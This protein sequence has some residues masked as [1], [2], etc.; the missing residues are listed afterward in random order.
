MAD[1][2]GEKVL[3]PSTGQEFV[4]RATD[5]MITPQPYS[6]PTDFAAQ[7][8]TP[9]DTTE[10]I[11]MCEEISVWN[12]IPEQTTGL[13]QE[14]WREMDELEF[15]S[16]SSYIA[17]ADG[18]CPEEYDHDGN[19]TT[20]SLKNLGAKKTLSVSDIKHSAAV[21]AA[22]WNGINNIL[23]GMGGSSGMPGGADQATFI[24]ET[25]GDVKDK[26]VRLAMT[27]VMNGWDRLLVEGD[28]NNNSLEFDGIENWATN[29]SCSMHTNDNSSSGTFSSTSY[30]RFLSESCA[31][32]TRIFGHPQAVQEMMSSYF[33]LGYQG[34]QIINHASGDRIIP[35]FNFA[36][37]VNTGVGRLEVVADTN[38]N[39]T[40]MGNGAFQAHLYALRMSHNGEPLVYKST[41][42]P[43]SMKDLA[44]GCTAISFE[45]WT[46]TALIIKACCAHSDYTSQFT[47]STSTT[48][49]VIG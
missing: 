16:G 21:A 37:F 19:N 14:T 9:L 42:I 11:A 29:Q 3:N 18:A 47:G 45:V 40:D 48:C 43:L 41:Q 46:K 31:K 1:V 20:I 4:A 13:K 25:V 33:Q 28:S 24:R 36:G 5:P 38:F 32:P 8:P 39:V 49:P 35:G 44:P 34:S 12:N 17:F 27:L 23:G 26:E 2:T 6:S 15:A 10:I 7:F 22:N 30:D